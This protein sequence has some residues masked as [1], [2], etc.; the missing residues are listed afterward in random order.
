MS[1]LLAEQQAVV[2]DMNINKIAGIKNHTHMVDINGLKYRV[3]SEQYNVLSGWIDGS[4]R[5]VSELGFYKG[6]KTTKLQML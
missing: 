4:L 2:N 3:G 6:V 5:A 1:P